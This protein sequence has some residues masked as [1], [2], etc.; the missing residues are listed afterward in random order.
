MLHGVT[1]RSLCSDAAAAR[2][3]RPRAVGVVAHAPAQVP[4]AAR[5]LP[6][7]VGGAIGIAA[8]SSPQVDA[9][10]TVAHA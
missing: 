2:S 6:M 8:S 9:A 10:A 1:R 4:A 5:A 7:V 3:F